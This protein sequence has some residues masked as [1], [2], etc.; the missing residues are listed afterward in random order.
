MSFR[1][2]PSPCGECGNDY[3]HYRN[4]SKS[5]ERP[6]NYSVSKRLLALSTSE[7]SMKDRVDQLTRLVIELAEQVEKIEINHV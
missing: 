1:I 3:G 7:V 4:C 6:E 5:S 2:G